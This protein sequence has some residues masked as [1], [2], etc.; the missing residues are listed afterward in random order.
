M[1][2]KVAVYSAITGGY[3]KYRHNQNKTGARYF[4][5]SDEYEHSPTWK[6][7]PS[8]N[9]YTDP[10]RN[11]RYHKLLPHEAFPD[12]DVW[13]WIDGSIEVK[14]SIP[15]LIENWM[16]GYD[17]VAF[18]HPDRNC[19]YDEATVVKGKGY[20]Y[21]DVID[22][23]V[24]KYKSEGYPKDWGLSET[25]IIMRYNTPEMIEFNK[26]WFYELTTGSLRDQLSFDY[27]VWKSG[28]KLNRVTPFQKGQEALVYYK[29]AKQREETKYN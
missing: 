19:S 7:L 15:F 26:L 12:F 4:M 24:R 25:K 8:T 21:P 29:H 2:L 17:I 10:R 16:I 22:R 27:C 3:E 20:D 1:R 23:Q 14:A 5:F 6:F 9:L 28:L 11:A 13:I 18:E